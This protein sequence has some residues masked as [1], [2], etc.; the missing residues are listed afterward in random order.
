MEGTPMTEATN[1]EAQTAAPATTGV[2]V[3]ELPN[4]D[5]QHSFDCAAMPAETRLDLLKGAARSYIAN[6]VNAAHQRHVKELAPFTAY[7]EAVKADPLQNAVA[8]PAGERPTVDLI[9]TMNRAMS[10]LLSGNIRQRGKGEGKTREKKDPLVQAVTKIVIGQVY[11]ARRAENSKYTYIMAQKDVG[12]DGVAYLKSQIEAKVA[13]GAD[14]APLEKYLEDRY[15]K[16]ARALVGVDQ[17]K[18]VKELP[19]IL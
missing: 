12:S 14:R 9:E 16:P 15:M 11:E 17:S 18:S 13:A 4:V 3:F 6:R 1:P 8:K 5:G 2:I 19:P 10:D 7:E